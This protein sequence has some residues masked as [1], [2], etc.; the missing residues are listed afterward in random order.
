M[1]YGLN[2]IYYLQVIDMF[3]V[4]PSFV[5]VIHLLFSIICPAVPNQPMSIW[6]EHLIYYYL[7][8]SI[9]VR[10]N[11]VSN[12]NTNNIHSNFTYATEP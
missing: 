9:D 5:K 1:I 3:R 11:I 8:N 10:Y 2:L 12:I 6:L 7:V 4:F